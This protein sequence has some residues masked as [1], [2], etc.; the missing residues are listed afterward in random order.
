MTTLQ[1]TSTLDVFDGPLPLDRRAVRALTTASLIFAFAASRVFLVLFHIHGRTDL[2]LYRTWLQQAATGRV[3]FLDFPI[4]YPP[5]AWW[6]IQIPATYQR[7][8]Y[9]RFRLLMVVADVGA[10]ALLWWI[11]SRRRPQAASLVAATYLVT[12]LALENV[13]YDRLDMLMLL[14]VVGGFAAW[15]HAMD[16]PHA[17][18]WRSVAYTA[19]ALGASYKLIPIVCL[20][21]FFIWDI[22]TARRRDVGLYLTLS[23]AAILVPFLVEYPRVGWASLGFLSYHAQRGIEIESLWASI[24]W[25]TSSAGTLSAPFRFGAVELA[26]PH[27]GLLRTLSLGLTVGT[28]VALVGWAMALKGRFTAEHAYRNAMMAVVGLLFFSEVFSPQYMIWALPL[29]VLIAVEIASPRELAVIAAACVV[30]AILTTVIFPFGFDYVQDVNPWAMRAILVRNGIYAGTVGW[31]VVCSIRTDMGRRQQVPP[32][33][34]FVRPRS[35]TERERAID[36]RAA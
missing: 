25:L 16:S 30:M 7:V 18:W 34:L 28:S 23:L 31:L 35:L 26:G 12:T 6:V 19:I 8:F 21:F 36:L 5:L 27:D 13:L 33:S 4:E 3:P 24:R 11:T 20:P 1:L 2:K 9:F 32:A 17:G 22:R 29:I 15:I 10:F 14:F